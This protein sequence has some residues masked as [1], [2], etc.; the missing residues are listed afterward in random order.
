MAAGATPCDMGPGSR[1]P[2][3]RRRDA[4]NGGRRRKSIPGLY[5]LGFL[6]SVVAFFSGIASFVLIA[7]KA[8]TSPSGS[9]RAT[10]GRLLASPG[11]IIPCS[12]SSAFSRRHSQT[13]IIRCQPRD[14]AS[15][16]S[17]RDPPRRHHFRLPC[18]VAPERSAAYVK[19]R[20]ILLD[21]CGAYFGAR[22]VAIR[23]RADSY[24][25]ETRPRGSFAGRGRGDCSSCSYVLG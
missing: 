10:A 2:I 23:R 17:P 4:R 25:E 5:A 22:P 13:R 3:V 15:R 12:A 6:A 21:Y 9:G 20:A 7:V 11:V 19:L 8:V 24:L 18:S 16:P 1:L 14:N